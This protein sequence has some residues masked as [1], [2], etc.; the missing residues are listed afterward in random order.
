MNA[1]VD[2]K[3]SDF[4]VA[5][6]NLAAWGR[7]ELTIAE[8]EMPGLV[9]TRAEFKASQPLKGAR[10]AGSLHMTIQTGVLIETLTALG[11]EVRWASCNIFSTQDH[12][13]AA[14]AAAGIPVFAFKGESL[15]EYWEYSHRIFEWPN[16]EFANMILDDGGDATLLLILGSKAEKDLSVVAN[17]TN[18]EEVALYAAI[19][20]HIEID[21]QW[22]SK[23]LSQIKG[24]TEETTTGVHRL[25]QMEKD[26][27]LPFPAIN[28]NDSVTKSKFDNLYGCRE[29]LVDGIKRATD[30]MIAGKIA[31]VAG[32]GDVG[33]GC[34]QSLRGLGA[35]VWVTEIDPICALQAA[36]EGY[37][38]VTMEYAADKADIFVTATGNFHVIDHDHMAAMKHQAIVCNI[39][40]FDSEINVASTR[41]YEW[42]NIKP[43]VD[44]IIFPDG[45]R[46]ILLAEGRLVNL[47]CATGHPSF[48]M[49][50]SFTNQTL[51]QIELFV[52]G[53][54]YKNSVYV[55]PKHLDEKVAR[56]HLGRIGA[57]LTVLSDDQ[58]KYISVDKNGP[59]KPSHYRY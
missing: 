27:T 21:P 41:K 22:Y 42:E 44:H 31:L 58:A 32:Y 49:S 15:D 51:A 33:K 57:E 30:V 9:A 59:F 28:V 55:L 56:L 52:H 34:A 23:R 1:V 10:I 5:D 38:V 3:F 18:E 8:S 24:V 17:P 26:G 12:A 46:I 14:I 7:K 53:A 40:H 54:K 19:K 39:G 29:S 2:S 48:V 50:N 4:H 37:R 16:G 36:M 13:A 25:Y 11:A 35:T 45:K 43:Q 47:G 20:R 6:I